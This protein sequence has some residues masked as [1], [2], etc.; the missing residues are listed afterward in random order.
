MLLDR[1]GLSGPA[2]ASLFVVVVGTSAAAAVLIAVRALSDEH[3]ARRVAPFVALAPAA[4]WVGVSADA[5]YAGVRPGDWPCWPWLP[6]APLATPWSSPWPP[7][8]CS[9]GPSTSATA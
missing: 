7:A 5:Y 9:A 2:W 6:P 8:C 1:V 4:V 3:L